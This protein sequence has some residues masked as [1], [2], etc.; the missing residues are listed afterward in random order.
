MSNHSLFFYPA[1]VSKSLLIVLGTF[2][3]PAKNDREKHRN[4]G[5]NRSRDAWSTQRTRVDHAPRR[6]HPSVFGLPAV[7]TNFL[8]WTRPRDVRASAPHLPLALLQ[9]VASVN[10]VTQVTQFPSCDRSAHCTV[11]RFA[12]VKAHG[13]APLPD[14]VICKRRNLD[15]PAVLVSLDNSCPPNSV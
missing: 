5:I 15:L 7:L 11:Q 4:A 1:I 3:L 14:K 9:Q 10:G 8:A 6:P 2:S 12:L 13:D